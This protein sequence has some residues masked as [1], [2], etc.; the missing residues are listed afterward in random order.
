MV[1]ETQ[2][3]KELYD[4]IRLNAFEALTSA[5]RPRSRTGRDSLRPAVRARVMAGLD[6][7]NL[8][9]DVPVSDHFCLD[10]HA[11]INSCE[12]PGVMKQWP[13]RGRLLQMPD[14]ADQ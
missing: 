13:R 4:T 1:Q 6:D 11:A 8:A 5:S 3:R 7:G 10:G 2:P 12:P 9:Q 14:T